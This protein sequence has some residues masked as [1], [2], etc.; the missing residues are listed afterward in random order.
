MMKGLLYEIAFKLFT[1]YAMLVFCVTKT[2]NEFDPFQ[3]EN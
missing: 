2:I 1:L 3:Y